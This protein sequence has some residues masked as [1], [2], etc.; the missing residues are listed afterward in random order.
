MGKDGKTRCGWADSGTELMRNYHD[1]E[2]GVPFFDDRTHFEF[3]IL[4]SAQAGLSWNTILNRREGYRHCFAN[5][6]PEQV[7]RFTESDVERL[8]QDMRIIRNRRKIESAINNARIFLETAARHGTFCN[9]IWRFTEG[10][11]LVNHW[12]NLGEMPAHTPL[13][14]TVAREMKRL[15]FRFL[16][17]TILYSHMQA[18]GMINDHLTSCFRHGEICGLQ[19]F[20]VSADP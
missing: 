15:G 5:F 8:M 19:S 9:W 17:S 12:K 7:A 3:L 11:P 20:P 10:R 2:W 18:I 1:R 6:D 13:S 14:D 4:E 16:G